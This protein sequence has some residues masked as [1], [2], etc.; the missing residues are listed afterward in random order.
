[1]P[2]N[3]NCSGCPECQPTAFA[4]AMPRNPG[5]SYAPPNSYA[6]ALDARHAPIDPTPDLDPNYNPATGHPPDGYAIALAI[7]K[8]M[9]NK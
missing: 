5:H 6:P 8:V 1:M 4:Y 3:P 2:H 9:E 7:R